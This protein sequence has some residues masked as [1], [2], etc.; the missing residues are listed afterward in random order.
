VEGRTP[1]LANDT[2]RLA[3]RGGYEVNVA[4]LIPDLAGLEVPTGER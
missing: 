2:L 1:E 4:V 3:S